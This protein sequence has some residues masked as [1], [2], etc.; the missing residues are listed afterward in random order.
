MPGA[1]DPLRPAQ[2]G[3][4][5]GAGE[6]RALAGH[7]FA[8]GS[9]PAFVDAE[10]AFRLRSAG[11]PDE[12]HGDLTLGL[13]P[14]GRVMLLLQSFNTISAGAGGPSF[15][16]WR[17]DSLAASVVY[18]LDAHWSLQAGLFGTIA[19]VN[20]NTERGAVVAVWRKF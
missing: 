4:T 3:D 18:E 19:A 12:W 13:R 14:W 17:S 15:P 10:A 20:T 1:R 2:A 5:G 8:I 11:P 7:N 9:W 6:V 16:A